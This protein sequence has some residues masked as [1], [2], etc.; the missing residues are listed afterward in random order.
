MNNLISR[1]RFL[2]TAA[3]AGAVSLGCSS[4]PAPDS[5]PAK[6]D[7]PIVDLHAHPNDQVPIS[8][9]VE[10]AR[11]RGVKLGILQHAGLAKYDYP[12]MISNDELLNQWIATLE[13]YPVYK[14]IQAE[15]LEWPSCFSKHVLARLDYALSDALTLPEPGGGFTKIWEPGLEIGDKQKWMDR[16]TD[17]HVEVMASEPIDILANPLFLPETIRGEFDELW[18]EKRMQT[19]IGAAVKYT[20][21]IEINSRYQLPGEKFLRLARDAG[22]KFSFGSNRNGRQVGTIEYSV[23]MARKLKLTRA[24]LFAP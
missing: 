22:A 8:E 17:F 23:A 5:A 13:P 20:V 3:A 6:R 10:L 12:H 11:Q 7:F 24:Q 2:G 14:G 9:Q 4:G 16:Y 15:G 1:R 18:T 19:I 21:A